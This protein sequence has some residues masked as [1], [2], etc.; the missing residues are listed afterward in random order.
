MRRVVAIVIALLMVGGVVVAWRAG[1]FDSD[2]LEAVRRMVRAVREMP[3]APLLFVLAY[4]LVV[5]LLLPTTIASIVAGAVFGF[6]GFA[7]AWAGLMLGSV[8]AYLLG[9]Y[10]G[11][12][13][14]ERFLGRHPLLERMRAQA[15]TWDLVRL[16]VLPIAPFGIFGYL[17]GMTMVS[18][19][20]LLIATGVSV[21]PTLA[22][23]AYAGAELGRAVETG[24]SAHRALVVAGATTVVV[25]ALAA[26]SMFLGKA[27]RRRGGSS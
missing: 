22:A 9:R 2:R 7:L 8:L 27:S 17:A 21:L 16:R 25:A 5:L 20:R 10:T 24:S 1:Y 12:R 13:V 18:F 23:Y 3:L 4:A 19:R 14:T 11:R 15:S 26:I 6:T